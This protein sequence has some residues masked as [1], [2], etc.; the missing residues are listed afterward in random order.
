MIE[1][2]G[3][4][5]SSQDPFLL[6]I[7]NQG[8]VSLN[9]EVGDIGDLVGRSSPYSQTFT[10]PFTNNNNRFFRQFYNIN[11]ETDLEL[12]TDYAV[13]DPNIKTPCD[14]RVDGIPIIT[15]SFQLL[16][17]SL[18]SRQYEIVVLGSESDFY[19]SLGDKKLIDAFRL[20]D[21]STALVDTYNVSISDAN[22]I[23]SW[24]LS[25]DVTE[26]GVG[27]GVIIFPIIDY[28]LV[29]DYNFLYLE[30][31]SIWSTGLAESGFLQPQDLRPSIQLKALFELIINKAG[32]TI[33]NNAFIASDAW[34][35]AYMTLGT[36]RESVAITTAHQS[37]VANTASATILTW[38][39]LGEDSGSWQEI[40]FPTQSGAGYGSN[41]PSLYDS[42][43][44]WNVGG[45]F[46]VPYTGSYSGVFVTSWNSGPSSIAQGAAVKG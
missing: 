23:D 44:D 10:L 29:G 34:T 3:Y 33:T 14:I 21:S 40:L 17:C 5:Q 15:G 31:D 12:T 43:D 11:V 4:N 1:L 46:I 42:G 13:F 18:K 2:Y 20:S 41:P 30:A 27:D 26:G 45:E 37:Q 19:N 25:N 32:F 24:D 7:Q 16:K 22:I 35:K 8:E 36:D 6:D 39:S 28:G 38:G 9:Y